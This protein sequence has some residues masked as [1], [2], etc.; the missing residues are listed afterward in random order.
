MN[1]SERPKAYP[2]VARNLASPRR[3]RLSSE[4][5]ITAQIQ[6]ENTMTTE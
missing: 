4:N 3:H 5:P 6:I 1:A 2:T